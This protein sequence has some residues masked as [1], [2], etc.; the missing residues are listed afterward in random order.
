MIDEDYGGAVI[1]DATST[2]V[3]DPESGSWSCVPLAS[4]DCPINPDARDA[5]NA[6][7]SAYL[8]A[9]PELSDPALIAGLTYPLDYYV[10]CFGF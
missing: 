4:Y 2:S 6:E 9:D 5:A 8:A 1:C 7:W 10:A 3:F